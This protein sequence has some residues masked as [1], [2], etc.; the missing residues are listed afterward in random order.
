MQKINIFCNIW[1]DVSFSSKMTNI[2]GQKI[3]KILK[4][5]ISDD[6]PIA[7]SFHFLFLYILKMKSTRTNTVNIKKN[8]ASFCL[9]NGNSFAFEYRFN[10]L[11]NKHILWKWNQLRLFATKFHQHD[12]FNS[13]FFLKVPLALS[14]NRDYLKIH[15]NLHS[16]SIITWS[17]N[18]FSLHILIPLWHGFMW[19]SNTKPAISIIT[20]PN[21]Q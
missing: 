1:N 5:S 10:S 16:N 7:K 3:A 4:L 18:Y 17:S 20:S 9:M 12:V 21:H 2:R 19:F 13:W 11:R 8:A 6:A 15:Y 14:T